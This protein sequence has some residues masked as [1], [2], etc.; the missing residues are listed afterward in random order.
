[1]IRTLVG[2]LL[3][4]GRGRF[5]PGSLSEIAAALDRSRAGTVVPAQGLVLE[6]VTY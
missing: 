2:T 4:I 1:M 3:E 5:P 6:K